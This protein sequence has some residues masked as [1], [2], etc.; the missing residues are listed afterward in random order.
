MFGHDN[1]VKTHEPNLIY[2]SAVQKMD[3]NS[4]FSKYKNAKHALLRP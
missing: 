2:R 3:S 1:T 4:D